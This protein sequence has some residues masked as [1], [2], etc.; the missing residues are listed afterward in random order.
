M[1]G[2]TSQVDGPPGRAYIRRGSQLE[3][4]LSLQVDGPITGGGG[5]GVISERVY[6]RDFM[7]YDQNIFEDCSE[8]IQQPSVIFGH[9]REFSENDQKC[10]YELQTVFGEFSETF[11]NLWEITAISLILLIV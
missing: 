9:L 8:I 2:L 1:E 4:F 7:V 11:E 6:N 5:G 10:S 3:Y